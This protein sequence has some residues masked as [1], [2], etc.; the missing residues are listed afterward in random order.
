MVKFFATLAQIKPNG[1][2]ELAVISRVD[3]LTQ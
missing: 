3:F 2:A 1:Q